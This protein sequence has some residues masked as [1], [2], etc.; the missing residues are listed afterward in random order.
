[1]PFEPTYIPSSCPGGHT[2]P[3]TPS[4]EVSSV[5]PEGGHCLEVQG[6]VL[7]CAS[8]SDYL[9]LPRL[10][11]HRDHKPPEPGAWSLPR[12]CGWTETVRVGLRCRLGYKQRAWGSRGP[13]ASFYRAV[14]R[15]PGDPKHPPAD[16]P[17]KMRLNVSF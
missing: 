13:A 16:P 17:T 12:H 7:R 4:G 11:H 2:H 9:W 15:G 3:Q 5:C 10:S 8:L 6:Q 1:M 14:I